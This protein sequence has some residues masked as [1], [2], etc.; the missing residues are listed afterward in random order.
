MGL[1]LTAGKFR[2]F[3]SISNPFATRT[4][5]RS[6]PAVLQSIKDMSHYEAAVG[7]YQLVVDLGN[8]TKYVPSA[9]LGTRTLF[10]AAGTVDSYVDMG[11]AAVTVTDDRR[12]ATV[13]LPHAALDQAALD[14]RNSHVYDKQRGLFNRIGDIFSSDPDDEQQLNILAVQKIDAA[15]ASS[16]LTD[17]AEQNT[18]VMLKGLL[19]SLGF[20]TVIVD[21][22]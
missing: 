5:D 19:G 22:K 10:V 12:G 14:P 7:T 9:L 3:S 6:Q 13:V 21:Y 15:A 1:F 20:T 16:G 4:V 11:R 2:L 17:R 8:E 18:T